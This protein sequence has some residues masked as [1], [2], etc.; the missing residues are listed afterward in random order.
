MKDYNGLCDEGEHS[1]AFELTAYGSAFADSKVFAD[2][3]SFFRPLLNIKNPLPDTD[4]PFITGGNASITHIKP[5]EDGN[6]IIV[7]ITEQSGK[8]SNVSVG[9]PSWTKKVFI[10]DLPERA[11]RELVGNTLELRA[12]ELATLRFTL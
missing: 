12:F 9:I 2:A 10:S 1:F 8:A 11:S 6:G 5:A 3:N 4:M 7:R